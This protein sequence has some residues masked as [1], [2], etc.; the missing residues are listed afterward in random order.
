MTLT[1]ELDLDV[2]PLDLHAKIQVHTSANSAF[3]VRRTDEQTD[4]RTHDAKTITPDMSEMWG[5]M[6]G[7]FRINSNLLEPS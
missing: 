2:F 3:I 5:V 7:V 4:K 6:I 1:F